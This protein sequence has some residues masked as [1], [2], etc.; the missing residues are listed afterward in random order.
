MR[1]PLFL[2]IAVLSFNWGFSQS[3]DP[4]TCTCKGK[5]LRGKVMKDNSSPD[6]KVKIVSSG[7][8]LAVDTS[9]FS[10]G[11]CGEWIFVRNS[12]DFKVKFVTTGE[13]FSV[14]FVNYDPGVRKNRPTDFEKKINPSLCTFKGIPL[15]GKVKIVTSFPDIRIQVVENFPDLEVKMVE[16]F[17]DHC[18]EWQLV[19]DF[20]DFTVQFVTSFP[21]FR[22]RYVTSFPGVK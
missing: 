1:F 5:S 18:G 4:Y 7:E 14:R 8:D 10:P 13:D 3:F 15:H 21:D 11:S 20:P 6:F 9:E 2:F 17:P 12:P 16:Y 22:I 19:E